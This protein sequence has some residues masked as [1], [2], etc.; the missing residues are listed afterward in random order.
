MEKTKKMKKM[1]KMNRMNRMGETNRAGMN[2]TGKMNRSNRVAVTRE[3]QLQQDLNLTV[4]LSLQRN[5]CSGKAL[6]LGCLLTA[7]GSHS[8]P[9]DMEAVDKLM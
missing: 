1:K 3:W 2:R 6:T 9:I 8:M 7:G 4:R 5:P